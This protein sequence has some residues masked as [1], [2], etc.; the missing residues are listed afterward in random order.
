MQLRRVGVVVGAALFS[1]S[2]YAQTEIQRYEIAGAGVEYVIEY[3]N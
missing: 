2:L 1:T 3:V